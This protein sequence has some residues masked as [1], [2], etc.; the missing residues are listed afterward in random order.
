MGLIAIRSHRRC[1]ESLEMLVVGVVHGDCWWWLV[2]VE[3]ELKHALQWGWNLKLR[4]ETMWGA[5][6][7]IGARP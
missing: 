4:H 2:A 1:L 6:E 3:G 5:G 7:V